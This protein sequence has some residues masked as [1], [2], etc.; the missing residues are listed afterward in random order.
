MY[1]IDCEPYPTMMMLEAR[2][3][4]CGKG[5][6]TTRRLMMLRSQTIRGTVLNWGSVGEAVESGLLADW[7]QGWGEFPWHLKCHHHFPHP[8]GHHALFM[9]YSCARYTLIYARHT[10]VIRRRCA[11]YTG[12]YS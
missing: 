9:R 1:S 2:I 12:C 6:D 3:S 7:L 4:A 10:L 11:T 8:S 5:A